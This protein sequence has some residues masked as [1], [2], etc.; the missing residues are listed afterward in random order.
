MGAVTFDSLE[1]TRRLEAGGFTRQQAESQ[2]DALQKVLERYDEADR[3]GLATK[4]DLRET[5]LRL[6]K[7]IEIIR[8]EI[9]KSRYDM[10]KWYIGGW[11]AMAVLMAKGFHWLGF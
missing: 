10:L 5:E 8:K 11:I 2:A 9:E 4:G 1:Y 7:E 6:Q 3:N